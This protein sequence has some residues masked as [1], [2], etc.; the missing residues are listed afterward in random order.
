M[1]LEEKPKDQNDDKEFSLYSE[2]DSTSMKFKLS[3]IHSCK[4]DYWCGISTTPSRLFVPIND[5]FAVAISE[6][7]FVNCMS[8][9]GIHTILTMV[10][11]RQFESTNFQSSTN[12]TAW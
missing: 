10:H 1:N 12:L 11:R 6:T 2:S 4:S 5:I 3:P 9:F 8:R 7:L